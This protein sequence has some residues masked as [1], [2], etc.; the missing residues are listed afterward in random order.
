MNSL[1]ETLDESIVRL[2]ELTSLSALDTILSNRISIE[3]DDL[4]KQIAEL[5]DVD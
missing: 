3:I 5:P 1:A 2:S 4:T